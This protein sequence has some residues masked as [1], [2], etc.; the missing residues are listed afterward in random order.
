[1]L[2]LVLS[3]LHCLLSTPC[4]GFTSLCQSIL[5]NSFS[6][7]ISCCSVPVLI[8]L[9]D[10]T[11]ETCLACSSVKYQLLL[12]LLIFICPP[13]LVLRGKNVVGSFLHFISLNVLVLDYLL[14]Y[15]VGIVMCTCS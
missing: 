12:G 7:S 14:N 13:I 5:L 8:I 6:C 4:K 15:A 3:F 2:I 9:P 11:F 10:S 1:M